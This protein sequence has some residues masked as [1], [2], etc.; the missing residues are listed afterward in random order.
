MQEFLNANEAKKKV[1]KYFM[2]AKHV[3]L[4]PLLAYFIVYFT[5]A[6]LGILNPVFTV[7]LFA[8]VFRR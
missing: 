5:F 8:D 7:F 6:V 1:F 3:A 4:D 2:Y